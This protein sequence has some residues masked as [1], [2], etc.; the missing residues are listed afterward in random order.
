MPLTK[1]SRTKEVISTF[2]LLW[3][4]FHKKQYLYKQQYRLKILFR[5]LI[6]EKN[7]PIH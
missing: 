2:F 6:V 5:L 7:L 1:A 3:G 4:V